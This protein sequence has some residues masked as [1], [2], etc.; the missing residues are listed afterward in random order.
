MS[1]LNLNRIKPQMIL[2]RSYD[3]S[4]SKLTI[5]SQILYNPFQPLNYKLNFKLKRHLISRRFLIVFVVVANVVV[6]V[7]SVV[8]MG[9]LD[10]FVREMVT[11]I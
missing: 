11:Y 9:A 4:Q 5:H 10:T 1:S 8:I 3:P 7:V 6:M 2:F